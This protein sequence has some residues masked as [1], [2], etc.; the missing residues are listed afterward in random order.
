[1]QFFAF[2][3]EN[4]TPDRF[5]YTGT[6]CGACDK[7]E[8]CAAWYTWAPRDG[9]LHK[10][11]PNILRMYSTLHRQYRWQKPKGFPYNLSRRLK[12][13]IF[14]NIVI[15]E[16]LVILYLTRFSIDIECQTMILILAITLFKLLSRK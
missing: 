11:L 14:F 10:I 15:I 8:V 4:F 9:Q 7:Y 12:Q 6:A 3:L 16:N 5:F 13:S 2:N 1:M